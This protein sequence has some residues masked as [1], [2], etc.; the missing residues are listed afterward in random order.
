M[1][2]DASR[3]HFVEHGWVVLRGVLAPPR[4]QAMRDAVEQIFPGRLAASVPHS[5]GV[6]H[7]LEPTRRHPGLAAWLDERAPFELAAHCLDAPRVQLLQDDLLFKRA[8][9]DDHLAWHQDAS[10]LGAL[11]PLRSISI[12]LALDPETEESGCMWILDRSH[13][14][15][16]FA[17]GVGARRVDDV[18]DRVPVGLRDARVP[19]AL[20][21]GDVSLHDAFTLHAS[22]PNRTEVPRRT[23]VVRVVPSAARMVRARMAPAF[24]AHTPLTPE[25]HLD[26]ERFPLLPKLVDPSDGPTLPPPIGAPPAPAR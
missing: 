14:H 23:L 22:P 3:A 6:P 24:A 5:D 8:R 19:L 18:L 11:E 16:L 15:G 7:M 2:L 9:A 21:P 10:Y 25:G 13:R 17:P 20:S 12:R 1:D 26:P 4:V